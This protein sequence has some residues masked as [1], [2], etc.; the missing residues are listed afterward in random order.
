MATARE[1]L[2]TVAAIRAPCSVKARTCFENLSFPKDITDCDIPRISS[3]VNSNM[4]SG[5]NRSALRLTAWFK[6]RVSTPD[7]CKVAI[8]ENPLFANRADEC[9][10]VLSRNNLSVGAHKG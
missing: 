1:L 2:R 5:G 7:C 9:R 3:R 4:K 8:Q 10:Y 6:A